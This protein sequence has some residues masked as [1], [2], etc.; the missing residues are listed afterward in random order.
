MMM[1]ANMLAKYAMTKRS[2]NL[3]VQHVHFF[4]QVNRV[5]HSC[6]TEQRLLMGRDMI[7]AICVWCSV[8]SEK[9]RHWICR[10][11][12]KIRVGR[13]KPDQDLY[14]FYNEWMERYQELYGSREPSDEM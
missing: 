4:A 10:D 5:E 2:R 13:Q 6:Q 14:Y 9:G 11:L 12:F 1:A 3:S 7:R 8:R